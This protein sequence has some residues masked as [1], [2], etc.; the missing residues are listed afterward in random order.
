MKE[1]QFC[2][3]LKDNLIKCKLCNHF[4]VIKEMGV[5]TC[6]VRKNITGELHSLVYGYPVA[7]NIDPVEKKP[8]YHFQPGSLTFSLG[9]YGCNF[10]CLNCQ[11]WDIS[12]AQNIE[13]KIKKL[14]FLSPEKIINE[15][16]GCDCNSIS[17]TY[18]EPT[19]FTEYALAIMKLAKEHNLSNIW[20]SNGYMSNECLESIIPYLD[21]INVDLKSVSEDFYKNNCQA[22]LNPVLDNLIKI[23]QEQIHLEI[24]TLIIPGLSDDLEMLKNLAEFIFKELDADTPWHLSKF[25]PKI[26]WQLKKIPATR[27]DVLYTVYEI[28]KDVG[29]KYI[30]LGNM[31]GDP[32]ENTY[33]PKCHELAISRLGYQI[34]RLDNN[35]RCVHCDKNLDIVE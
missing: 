20:V 24:T 19:I 35:G 26:S 33:C 32:K 2:K 3:K 11:N 1:A 16:L 8:L 13:E 12:Q 25:S 28:G 23:K 9:T 22:K 14:E 31:P 7:L 6:S 15:A 21:A 5:G 10:K 18:N 4:C 29:L 34:E 17:Y 30:Y 27:D